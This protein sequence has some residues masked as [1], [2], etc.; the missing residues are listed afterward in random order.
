MPKPYE[1]CCPSP[2]KI[3]TLTTVTS[4]GGAV[5]GTA[6]GAT[7]GAATGAIIGAGVGAAGGVIV[8]ALV[9]SMVKCYCTKEKDPP[10]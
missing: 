4:A 6:T 5:A 2:P 3:V 7:I 1:S 10:Y 8:G 9:G